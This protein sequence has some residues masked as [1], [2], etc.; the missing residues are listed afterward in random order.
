MKGYVH[1]FESFGTVDGPGTRFVIFLQGC[2]LRCLYCHNP[3]TWQENIGTEYSKE[4][5]LEKYLSI[6][7]FV[8]GGIT[9]TG[10]EPLMQMDFVKELFILFKEHNIHTCLDTSG[11]TFTKKRKQEFD[12]LMK[13]TDLVLLDIKHI[14]DDEHKL[15][16]GTNNKNILDFA[17][18]LSDINKP[19]WI[20]HVV[21][22]NITLNDEY[23]LQLGEFLA[24]LNNI[25]AID[26]LPFH[27]M[28]QEKYEQLNLEFPLK[29]TKEATA[30]D[31][32]HARNMILQGIKNNLYNQ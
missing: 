14:S 6:K 12:E 16:T 8:K 30:E 17:L 10:G 4:E 25:K 31:S 18:Y 15:L 1:S 23:L 13:Y 26:V 3:D 2:P 21:I 7:E 20:R 5:I 9:V 11:I 22:E 27:K 28:G 29:N 32:I 19:V 24:S